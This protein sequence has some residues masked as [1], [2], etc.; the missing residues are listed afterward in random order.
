MLK[1]GDRVSHRYNQDLGPGLVVA[2]EGRRTTV[3]FPEN[4]ETLHF[5]VGSDALAKLVLRPGGRAR[6]GAT[7]DVV[8]IEKVVG[9][10]ARLPD[11]RELPVNDLWP[12]PAERSLIDRLSRGEVDAFEDFRNRLDGLRLVRS[13][14]AEGLGSFL[15]GRIRLFPHQLYAAEQATRVLEDESSAVRW[16]LAD[17][18]GLGKTVEACLIMNRLLHRKL[19]DR[20]LVVAPDTLTVQWL[21]ELWR[22]HHQVFVLLDE[23]RLRDV[24]RDHGGDFNPFDVHRRAIVSQDLLASNRRLAEHA[25]SAGIDL[26]V[27]DEAHRLR[28][29]SGHPGN[30]LYRALRPIADLGRHVLL[31]TATPLEDDA[32]GFFRLLQLLRPDEFTEANNGDETD[33]DSLLTRRLESRAQLPPCTSATRRQ[34]VG[35]L[36]PRRPQLVEIED[37]DGWEALDRLFR[38][39]RGEH[40]K[41]EPER[42]RKIDLLHRAHSSPVALPTSVVSE[43][44][45]DQLALEAKTKDPRVGWL[46]DRALA[47]RRDGN[48]VLVF[49]SHRETL[50]HLKEVLS[51]RG[52]VRV[53]IFHE[54]LSPERRDMEVAQFR[55]ADGPGILISTEAGGEGRNFEFCDRLVLFDLPWSPEVVEQRIGRLDRIGRTRDTEIVYFRPPGGFGRTVVDL[56]EQIG[57]FREALGSL[58]RELTNVGEELGRLLLDGP[59][60][61]GAEPLED[62]LQEATHAKEAVRESA[63]HEMHRDPYRAA[64]AEEILGRVPDDLDDLHRDVV[65]R[66]A[67][68]FGFETEAQSG[69]DV[70]LIEYSPQAL[71]E[72]L[73]GVPPGRKFLGT[74]DREEAVANEGLDFF[75]SGHPLVE[76]ILVELEDGRR[77]R[78]AMFRARGS[79]ETFGILALYKDG[80]SVGEGVDAVAVDARG[81][82]RPDLANLLTSDD[83]QLESVDAKSWSK[84]QGWLQGIRKIAQN[85]PA[86]REPVAV[87]AFRIR[88]R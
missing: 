76:G 10:V 65:L 32:L 53:G 72:H 23:D 34:D 59:R 35:G 14:V 70:W 21:G 51:T 69:R 40:A 29:R 52:K 25:V 64:V 8:E 56:Y 5:A 1:E 38:R 83:L 47:W 46:A 77:G 55:L 78:V 26:L 62:V 4:G 18:V 87:A 68:R 81:Q 82:I 6:H 22:K 37:E 79:E 27:V 28:R 61:P 67:A 48:K 43:S 88:G 11:G 15:G 54:D 24:A 20:T 80:E 42:Q 39:L 85:L 30:A 2:V 63:Y 57:L 9:D 74:F 66:A 17:E 36:P 3:L 86:D 73:P 50:E 31:L 12:V 45:F 60:T 58:Q 75:A 49:V 33:F 16:L 13:R 44:P 19:V 71:V 84:R 41:T 7:G